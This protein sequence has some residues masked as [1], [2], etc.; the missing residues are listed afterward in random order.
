MSEPSKWAIEAANDLLPHR[1][2]MSSPEAMAEYRIQDAIDQACAQKDAEIERLTGDVNSLNNLLRHVGW[3][4][5]EIDSSATIA[6]E[7]DELNAL[8]D[9]QRTRMNEAT[10]AW[11]EAHPGKELVSPD[12][13]GL[14]EW[15]LAEIERLK[16]LSGNPSFVIPWLDEFDR[17]R[18]DNAQKDAFIK[19]QESMLQEKDRRIAELVT[20]RDFLDDLRRSYFA[21]LEQLKHP[22]PHDLGK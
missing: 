9:L 8:F 18:R 19:L 4:Q 7:L 12:L 11:R 10:A 21:E 17:C 6:E 15:L 1:A 3:G 16:V 5:G 14:L 2:I 20:Q 22:R 13:G